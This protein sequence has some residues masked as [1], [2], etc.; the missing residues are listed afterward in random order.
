[1]N[2]EILKNVVYQIATRIGLS[3]RAK[4]ENREGEPSC[5]LFPDDGHPNESFS[6]LFRIGWRTASATVKWGQFSGSLLV[7]MS[8]A[9][10]ESKD[11][12]CVFVNALKTKKIKVQMR[13]NGL[14]VSANMPS[15][16]PEKWSK[17][18]LSLKTMQLET[19]LLNNELYERLM[20]ELV[21]PLFGMMACLIGL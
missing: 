4:Y 21:V 11:A 19:D 15:S 10:N 14:E 9:S 7:Q 13:I 18:D 5:E 3:V 20:L 17:L 1:L 6:V 12:F 16:W 8:Q 2:P